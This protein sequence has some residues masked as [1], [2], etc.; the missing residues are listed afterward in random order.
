MKFNSVLI[1]VVAGC[2]MVGSLALNAVPAVAAANAHN[3]HAALVHVGLNPATCTTVPGTKSGVVTV[4]T[5]VKRKESH[6]NI[7]VHHALPKTVYEV[8]I[9]CVGQIGT[10]KTNS[11]GTG[12]AHI[13]DLAPLTGTFYVDLS[14]PGG[15]GGAG[16]FGDTFIAGPFS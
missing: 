14:V 11:R 8:D 16:G 1:V 15:G 13:T 5:N 9:R 7:S 10:L 3:G 6:I 12:T 4:H 2:W